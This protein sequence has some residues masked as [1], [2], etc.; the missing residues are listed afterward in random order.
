MLFDQKFDDS[1]EFDVSRRPVGETS[2][3][4]RVASLSSGSITSTPD[5]SLST[6]TVICHP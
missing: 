5:D 4:G 3:S 6:G 2:G 1:L